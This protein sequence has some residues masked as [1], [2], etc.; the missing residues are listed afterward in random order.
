MNL[1]DCRINLRKL[2]KKQILAISLIDDNTTKDAFLRLQELIPRA[3]F[4]FVSKTNTLDIS[5]LREQYEALI[6]IVEKVLSSNCWS[7]AETLNEK[8]N[9][10]FIYEIDRDFNVNDNFLAV[11]CTQTINLDNYHIDL[12]GPIKS[13]EG[14]LIYT[15]AK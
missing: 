15:K 14:E 2:D 11:N 4:S 12:F 3:T 9:F 5:S 13:V 6:L 8:F 7:I 10:D 1:F